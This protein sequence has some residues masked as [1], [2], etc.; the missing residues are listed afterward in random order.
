MAPETR[1]GINVGAVPII[2]KVRHG[3]GYDVVVQPGGK[4]DPGKGRGDHATTAVERPL[5]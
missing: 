1:R 5:N 3:D 4:I 2:V